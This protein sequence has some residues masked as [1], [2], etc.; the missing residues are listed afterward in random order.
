M[1][2]HYAD[3]NAVDLGPQPVRPRN[4]VAEIPETLVGRAIKIDDGV[5]VLDEVAEGVRLDKIAEEQAHQV[6]TQYQRDR[7]AEYPKIGDQLDA[8]YKKFYLDD[9]S[10]YDTIAVQIE[11]VKAKYPKPE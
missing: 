7:A 9:S 3:E 1:K 11:A 5:A 10:E 2:K 4:A 8:I 6:A